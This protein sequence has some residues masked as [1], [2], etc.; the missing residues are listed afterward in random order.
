MA[1]VKGLAAAVGA[2]VVSGILTTSGESAALNERWYMS[3][4]CHAA[5]W[6]HNYLWSFNAG[7]YGNESPNGTDILELAC[8][9]PH[10][11]GNNGHDASTAVVYDQNNQQV[12]RVWFCR[13]DQTGI[14]ETCSSSETGAAFSSWEPQTLT[15]AASTSSLSHYYWWVELPG[16]GNLGVSSVAA[17][18][19]D[20]N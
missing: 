2:L 4:N 5:W 9:Q 7:S 3:A 12:V 6:P 16:L 10:L 15:L 1:R 13:H 18:Y 20:D 8:S 14:S 17:M 11:F 19:F